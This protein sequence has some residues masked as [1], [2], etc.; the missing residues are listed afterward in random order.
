[1]EE[2][3]RTRGKRIQN[4]RNFWTKLTW[5]RK[6]GR[7]KGGPTSRK[8]KGSKRNGVGDREWEKGRKGR[9]RVTDM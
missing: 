4:E 2:K 3:R 8:E 7:K 5:I 9:K 6:E 1:M